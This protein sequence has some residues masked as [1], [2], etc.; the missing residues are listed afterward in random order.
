MEMFEE[1]SEPVTEV[2]FHTVMDRDKRRRRR[3][4]KQKAKLH[5]SKLVQYAGIDRVEEVRDNRHLKPSVDGYLD[6]DI[7]FVRKCSWPSHNGRHSLAHTLKRQSNR[8]I[9]HTAKVPA[10]GGFKKV[11]DYKWL[12][13]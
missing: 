13:Y 3:K 1:I 8:K 7:L 5:L 11:M 12:L 4:A 10:R 9:R 6:A 2:T